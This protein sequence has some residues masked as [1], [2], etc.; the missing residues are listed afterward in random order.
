MIA[1]VKLTAI[2][3]IWVQRIY[4]LSPTKRLPDILHNRNANV[5]HHSAGCRKEMQ[6][7]DE[8]RFMKMRYS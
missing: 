5:R 6:R 2:L 8:H 7:E 4:I 3:R 1:I